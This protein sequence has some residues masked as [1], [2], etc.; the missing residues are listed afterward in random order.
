MRWNVPVDEEYTRVWTF[1]PVRK[2]K[3][4][5]GRLFQDFWYYTYRKPSIVVATNEKEDLTVFM[6]D[7]LNLNAP[8]KLGPL[9]TGVIYFRRHLA[10]RARDYERLGR[11]QGTAKGMT[12]REPV[13]S[14]V[15][16]EAAIP[17]GGGA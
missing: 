12:E 5:L 13:E 8:Q 11:V 14:S 2:A 1:T 3:T 7:R 4:R 17:A 6:K 15:E 16:A 10:R 9:D